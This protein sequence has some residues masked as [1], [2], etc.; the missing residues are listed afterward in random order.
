M[1]ISSYLFANLLLLLRDDN[2]LSPLLVVPVGGACATVCPMT[3]FGHVFT[4]R[5]YSSGQSRHTS[6]PGAVESGFA[7]VGKLTDT[8]DDADSPSGDRRTDTAV[9]GPATACAGEGGGRVAR[10]CG[11]GGAVAR[12]KSM[13]TRPSQP[14]PVVGL[15]VLP[16]ATFDATVDTVRC[17]VGDECSLLM[18]GLQLFKCLFNYNSG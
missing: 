7:R 1:I 3:L 15:A 16:T 11:V 9:L 4:P 13:K 6:M 12:D 5:A 2:F 14:L 10:G 18:L 8:L 17:A